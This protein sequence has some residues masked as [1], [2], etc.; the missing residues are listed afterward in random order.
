MR[1][2]KGRKGLERINGIQSLK[3]IL[4]CTKDDRVITLEETEVPY[5]QKKYQ[6]K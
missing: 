2:K 3:Y 6:Y 5:T 1:E 4:A